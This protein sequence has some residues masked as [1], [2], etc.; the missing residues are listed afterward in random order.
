MQGHSDVPLNADGVVQAQRIGSRLSTHPSPPQVIYSSNLSRAIQTAEE[1]AKPLGI[2]VRTTPKL[3]ETM[4]GEW[5]GLT[6]T[7]IIARGDGV[8][9]NEY[10]TDSYKSRPPG[11]ESLDAV[12]DRM[13]KEFTQIRQD[14]PDSSIA[15]V[16]HGGSLRSIICHTLDAEVTSMRRIWLDNASLSVLEY[17][18]SETTSHSRI[19]LLNDTSHLSNA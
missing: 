3:R 18:E 11:G 1:I 8:L 17:S 9:L 5:E 4:L 15:I 7:E 16:G 10:I 14:H 2:E 6:R 12:W 19:L 13:L